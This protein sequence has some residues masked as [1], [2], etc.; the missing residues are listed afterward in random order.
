M[1]GFSK[2][3]AMT[4]WR[5]GY[6]GAPKGIAK[7]I[8]K[9]QGQTT[10][11]NCSIAQRA[12]L[13]ALR[14][15][16][17]CAIEMKNSYLKRRDLV[18]DQL[19]KITNL[20]VNLPEGAFYFFPEIDN[21]LGKRD[22]KGVEIKSSNDLAMYLLEDAKIS[23]VPGD[24]FGASNCIRLSYAASESDLI[25]ACKRLDKSIHKLN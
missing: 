23:L 11:A 9:M 24:D 1:N 16:N 6:M 5:L 4:G 15:G 22:S 10:S 18:F 19:N 3:F 20:K 8:N 13:A 17:D 25:E 2:A 21:I 12:G 7:S 14:A